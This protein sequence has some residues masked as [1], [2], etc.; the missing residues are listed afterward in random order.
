MV[1]FVL[2]VALL[3][4]VDEP[5]ELDVEFDVVFADCVIEFSP[6]EVLLSTAVLL[7]LSA[8]EMLVELEATSEVELLLCAET[9]NEV[10]IITNNNFETIF[11]LMNIR[12]CLYYFV[13]ILQ[14]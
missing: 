5:V 6:I 13:L 4:L 11:E 9:I 10:N 8:N 12:V 14:G 1:L 7:L 3:L 2:V